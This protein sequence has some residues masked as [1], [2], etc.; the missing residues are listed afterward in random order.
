MGTLLWGE[1][2]LVVPEYCFGVE[3]RNREFVLSREHAEYRWVRY[4][5]AIEMLHWD[6]NKN[7]LWELNHHLLR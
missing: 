1:G 6:S 4:D 7:A 5:S 2:V 3:V